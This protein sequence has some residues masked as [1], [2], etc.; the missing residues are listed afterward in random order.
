DIEGLKTS[1]WTEAPVW[2]SPPLE[3]QI[4][5]KKKKKLALNYCGKLTKLHSLL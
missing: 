3:F 1:Y 2:A 4:E 5:T